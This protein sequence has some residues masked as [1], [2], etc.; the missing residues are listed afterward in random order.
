[1]RVE[2]LRNRD[3]MPIFFALQVIFNQ[4][5]TLL[6]GTTNP[7]KVSVRSA[8]FDWLDFYLAD[9][10]AREMHSRLSKKKVGS[11]S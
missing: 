8:F 10:Q 2:E 4:D 3:V 1:M 6:L 5:Q 9:I 7:I 11:H